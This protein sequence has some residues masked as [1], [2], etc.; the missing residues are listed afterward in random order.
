MGN[1]V[2][3]FFFLFLH[4]VP[5]GPS[6]LQKSACPN[7]RG[8]TYSLTVLLHVLF[9]IFSMSSLSRLHVH[10]STEWSAL[11]CK[12]TTDSKTNPNTGNTILGWNLQLNTKKR[13]LH[14]SVFKKSL[15]GLLILL[16]I[17]YNSSIYYTIYSI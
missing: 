7:K 14:R 15:D 1:K 2:P 16:L 11:V 4:F 8:T 6:L 17:W 5:Q 13:S 9:Y 12:G 3:L 10:R